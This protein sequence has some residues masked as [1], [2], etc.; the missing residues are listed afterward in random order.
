MAP[1]MARRGGTRPHGF[2]GKFQPRGITRRHIQ[3]ALAGLWLLDGALQLQPFMFTHGFAHQVIAPTGQG[4]PGF[5][6]VGV[7]FAAGL[8]AAHPVLWDSLFA[9]TQL[10]LGAGLLWRRTVRPALLG[11][12][13]W[14][15]SVWYLG[16]GLGGVASGHANLLTGFP[17]AILLYALLAAVAWPSPTLGRGREWLLGGDSD[18][19]PPSWAALAWAVLWLGGA[20]FRALPGQS[21]AGAISSAIKADTAGAPSWLAFIDKAV[22]SGVHH[23]GFSVVA[24][25][26]AL[27]ALIAIP[28]LMGGRWRMAAVTTGI[29]LLAAFWVFGQGLGQIYTGRSTDPKAAPLLALLGLAL[30][31]RHRPAVPV[32]S[33][34]GGKA[35]GLV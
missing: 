21:T 3:L 30:L 5:V 6:A 27:E 10:A 16:E 15:L 14:G 1:V 9:L 4:Q 2:M 29:V 17:G 28:A 19:A 7:G 8:I 22:A 26:F 31:G 18:R 24:G 33:S 12:M 25:L 32:R 23:V 11:S 13:V 34:G 35:A 20:A